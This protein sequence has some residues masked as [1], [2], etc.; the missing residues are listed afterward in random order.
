MSDTYIRICLPKKNGVMHTS[1]SL[2]PSSPS[3]YSLHE[4]DNNGKKVGALVSIP[5]RS[6]AEIEG[7]AMIL[8]ALL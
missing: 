7:M 8:S 3:M 2:F 6:P 4:S 1:L 5:S